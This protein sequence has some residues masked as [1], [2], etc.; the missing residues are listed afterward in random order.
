[1]RLYFQTY[2]P[3][4]LLELGHEA[5]WLHHRITWKLY[6]SVSADFDDPR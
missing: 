3:D 2:S 1:M 4:W 6:I 5:M